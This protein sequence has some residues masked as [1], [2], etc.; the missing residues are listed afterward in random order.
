MLTGHAPSW[1][2]RSFL[3]DGVY[4]FLLFAVL[5]LPLHERSF[6]LLVDASVLLALSDQVL[7]GRW[8]MRT[9]LTFWAFTAFA[10]WA[11]YTLQNS[12]DFAA[13]LY[14]Y[15]V[16]M[17]R[18]I[19]W[20]WLVISYVKSPS[21][22][23]GIAAMFAFSALVVAGYGIY[24]YFYMDIPLPP[25]W[26]DQARF[27]NIK[28]RVFSTLHNPNILGAFL[29]SAF[30]LCMGIF[31]TKVQ[32][33]YRLLAFILLAVFAVCLLFT[34]SRAAW[35]TALI[36]AF[37]W[38]LCYSRRLLLVLVPPVAALMFYER[39]LIMQ[40]LLSAFDGTDT[41]SVLRMALWEST[42]V[43]I[44]RHPV[45]GIGWGAYRFLYPKYD[46]FIKDPSI[47][48]YHAHNTFLHYA[49]ELGIVGLLLF[50]LFFV[51]NI[52]YA[53][54]SSRKAKDE[55]M[56]A[57]ARGLCAVFL[58]VFLGS[59]TDHTLFS[60]QMMSVFL[61]LSGLSY[62]IYKNGDFVR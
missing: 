38:C 6:E 18:Y 57:L 60:S 40:R 7:S 45:S 13:S 53:V 58:A 2:E 8:K 1:R 49:A 50:V 29:T 19:F 54:I 3:S 24:Q 51:V 27:T 15:Q 5:M 47:I 32:V 17:P 62:C 48:I 43:M 12:P 61:F 41:S 31:V 14:N 56:Q 33:L 23:C 30:A 20:L 10:L 59:L 52:C 42:R 25:E 21:Q 55:N 35:L 9:P 26:V 44:E 22:I 28:T 16:L 34:F 36:V 46:F 4:V 37:L 39:A 11:G